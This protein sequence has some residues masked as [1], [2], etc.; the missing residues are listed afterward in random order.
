MKDGIFKEVQPRSNR[1]VVSRAGKYLIL[2]D[3]SSGQRIRIHHDYYEALCDA[4]FDA[5]FD[6]KQDEENENV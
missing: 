3:M 2:L 4:L 1:V 6:I 5:H